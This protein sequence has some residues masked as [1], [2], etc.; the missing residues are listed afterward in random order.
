[1][2]IELGSTRINYRENTSNDYVILAQVVDSPLSYEKP[3]IIRSVEELDIWFGRN[4]SDREYLTE[5]LNLGISLYLYKPVSPE[6]NR[7]GIS[8][9]IDF[10]EYERY[11]LVINYYQ[12]LITNDDYKVYSLLYNHR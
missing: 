12:R 8:G 1:M 7:E 11:P 5:L 9:Y 3:N 2:Y 6:P 4:Y 10:S